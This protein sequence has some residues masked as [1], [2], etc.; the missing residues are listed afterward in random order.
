MRQILLQEP[1]A[2]AIPLTQRRDRQELLPRHVVLPTCNH[3]CVDVPP[4]RV[5]S[6][7]LATSP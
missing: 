5:T 3:G 7:L 1:R 2:A 4:L 6:Q